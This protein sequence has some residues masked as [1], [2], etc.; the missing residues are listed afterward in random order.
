M[1]AALPAAMAAALPA[2]MAA[3]LPAAMVEVCPSSA[4]FLQV[5]NS[6]KGFT[7]NKYTHL[8]IINI[9]INYKMKQ[10]ID[11][12]IMNKYDSFIISYTIREQTNC[13]HQSQY[14]FFSI[15][16]YTYHL[17]CLLQW[18]KPAKV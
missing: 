2:A 10:F 6:E 13:V 18:L 3:A 17:H 1:A 9:L 12:I 16:L 15:N 8:H 5:A 4:G 14:I 7:N 11:I